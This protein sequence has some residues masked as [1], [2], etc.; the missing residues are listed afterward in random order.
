MAWCSRDVQ[1]YC[2]SCALCQKCSGK[3]R[4]PNVPLAKMPRIE[5]P[6]DMV[7]VDIIGLFSPVSEGKHRY[8]LTLVDVATR[9]PEA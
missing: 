3:G 7:A 4:T 2:R 5:K 8:V 6:F 9:F 1:R